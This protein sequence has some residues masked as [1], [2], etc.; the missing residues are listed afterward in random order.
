MLGAVG[1]P[2][3]YNSVALSPDGTKVAV[4]RNDPQAAGSGGR[5]PNLD[6]WVYEFSHGTS[7]RLTFDPAP[8]G[9]AVWSPDG[10]RLA[11]ASSGTGIF[12]LYQKA[13]NG[14]GNQDLLLKSGEPKASYDWSPDGRWLLYGVRAGQYN[15]W[16][17]PLTGEDR[18]PVRYL[19]TQFNESQARFSPDGRFIAYTS[20]ESGK[21]EVYVQ[22]FPQASGG[23]W[24]VSKG[25]GNQPQ[26]RRDGKELFYISADSKMMAVDVT[27]TPAFQNGN[28]KALFGAPIFGTGT[29]PAT[30]YD[31]TPDNR[32]FL[33][34]TRGTEAA[35]APAGSMTVV[36]NWQM[37]LRR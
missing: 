13:S 27:T 10:S 18:K 33:I 30:R 19:A 2:G 9:F 25:G 14:M 20:D 21:S 29:G 22:P 26:W 15:L 34:N 16:Y 4:S 31:V 12:D 28:P 23:K 1:E 7:Q 35:A 17:L 3:Y 32:K 11:F 8:D 6:I 36:V 37:G 24:L 5:T